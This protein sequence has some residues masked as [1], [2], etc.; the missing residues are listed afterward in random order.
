MGKKMIALDLDGTL[1]DGQRRISKANWLAVR[2]AREMGIPVVLCSGRY[3]AGVR[4]IAQLAGTDDLLV[5][6]NGAQIT[7]AQG[8]DVFSSYMSL[9]DTLHLAKAARQLKLP[10]SIYADNTLYS[11]W[12]HEVFQYYQ[13]N[14]CPVQLLDTPFPS[15]VDE[16]S[17]ILK[18]EIHGRFTSEQARQLHQ[19]ID[20]LDTVVGEGDF[21]HSVECHTKHVSKG[22]GLAVAA[23]Y[24]GVPME[25]VMAV[26]NAEN[27]IPMLELA[28][29]GVAVANAVETL[30]AVAR[31]TVAANEQDGVAEA[32]HWFCEL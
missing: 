24:Y 16:K 6:G 12:R 3:H 29:H 32:I 28:G 25:H 2:R 8:Q 14:G 22:T 30:K 11:A 20:S 10:F 13:N 9:G 27:D 18:I 26:G 21:Y 1:L 15:Q 19:A 31:R 17:N 4:L 5:C 23:E 7:T